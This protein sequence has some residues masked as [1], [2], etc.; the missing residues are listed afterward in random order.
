MQSPQTSRCGFACL[1]RII[2]N[3]PR[4]LPRI[5]TN[6]RDIVQCDAT[7]DS[8]PSRRQPHEY[9]WRHF[10]AARRIIRPSVIAGKKSPASFRRAGRK[11][12]W[13]GEAAKHRVNFRQQ[14][15]SCRRL[16]AANVHR[17]FL[18]RKDRC[19]INLASLPLLLRRYSPNGSALVSLS[20]VVLR[21]SS[22][23]C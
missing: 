1:P 23:S 4:V 21:P 6:Y 14:R 3:L 2:T 11:S 20:F 8:S 5:I 13:G 10:R 18:L 17:K 19:R 22:K 15:E 16:F 12:V 9:E 7:Y